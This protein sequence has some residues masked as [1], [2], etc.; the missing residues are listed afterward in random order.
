MIGA[1]A[2]V[3]FCSGVAGM[4]YSCSWVRNFRQ[5]AELWMRRLQGSFMEV[6]LMTHPFR[7]RSMNTGCCCPC[8]CCCLCCPGV[9]LL[10]LCSIHCVYVV[11]VSSFS[12]AVDDAASR[13]ARFALQK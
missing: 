2:A 1:S 13:S 4:R 5:C 9:F 3:A 12:N 8:A 10:L 6:R 7:G 11:K